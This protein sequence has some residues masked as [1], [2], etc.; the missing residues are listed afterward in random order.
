[1]RRGTYMLLFLALW[2]AYL[3]AEDGQAARLNQEGN[4]LYQEGK[5]EEAL[6]RYAEALALDP[7][8]SALQYNLGNALYRA[9]RFEEALD[10]YSQATAGQEMNTDLGQA[11]RFNEGTASLQAEDFENAVRSLREAVIANPDD[12]GG[13]RNLELALARMQ[14]EQQEQQEQ[15]Q[16][17][18]EDQEESGEE[19]QRESDQP[20]EGENEQEQDQEGDRQ[21]EQN[22]DPQGDAPPQPQ[23]NQQDEP[24]ESPEGSEPTPA[25]ESQ[26]LSEEEAR[27]LLAALDRDEREELKESLEKPKK[28][29]AGG[30]R[31]W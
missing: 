7:E 3:V 25:E 16:E 2:P 19:G 14:Q 30:G 13:R 4:A 8:S 10:A 27:R 9:G 15:E 31:D 12:E 21:S 18:E 29:K 28:R 6:N 11:A 26:D 22:P 23:G 20:Q 24:P 1:M 17:G 5:L